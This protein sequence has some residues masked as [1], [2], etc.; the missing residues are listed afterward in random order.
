MEA[1]T[2]RPGRAPLGP[3]LV[4]LAV[5]LALV[6]GG[7]ELPGGALLRALRASG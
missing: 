4:D 1:T 2:R 5:A 7:G 3:L 6:A